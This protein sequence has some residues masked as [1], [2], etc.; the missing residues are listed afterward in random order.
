MRSYHP[1]G[2]M[3]ENIRYTKTLN[4]AERLLQGYTQEDVENYHPGFGRLF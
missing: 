1:L 4:F 3:Q 2:A